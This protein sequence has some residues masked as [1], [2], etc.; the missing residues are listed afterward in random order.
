[1]YMKKSDAEHLKSEF[2]GLLDSIRAKNHLIADHS[3]G[4]DWSFVIKTQTLI[5]SAITN[6]VL[7]KNGE[8]G[9]R[10]TFKSMPLVGD[11][12][13]KLNFSKELGITT[14]AQR[15][16][17][18]TM[19]SLR[20]QLAHN[21]DYGEFT[22]DAYINGLNQNQRKEW[23]QAI[24][25]FSEYPDSKDVWAQNSLKAPKSVIYTSAFML[26]ALLE[27]SSTELAVLRR[28]EELSIATTTELLRGISL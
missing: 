19:A 16:F 7:S 12:A 3:E 5:E 23:Q 22:F 10:K 13:S 24:P 14:S 20:N 9:L 18:T 6:A 17:I 25:W 15:R 28:I 2:T 11:G 21:P 8:N 1:M 4:D 26:I 27:L